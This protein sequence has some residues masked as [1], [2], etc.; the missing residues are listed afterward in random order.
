[1]ESSKAMVGKLLQ[2][3]SMHLTLFIFISAYFW[4]LLQAADPDPVMDIPTSS[5]TFVLRDLFTN[6]DVSI[7]TGGIRAA[8]N[9]TNLPLT[10][11]EGITYVRFK[12][13]PCGVNL[14]HTH[15][16]AAE[17]LTLLSGGPLQ[18][19][20][21]DTSG[22]RHI[23]IIHPGDVTV[24][25]RGLLHYEIN[26]GNQTARYISALNSQNPGT[27]TASLAL[28]RVPSRALATSLNQSIE[29]TRAIDST[30]FMYGSGLKLT[31]RSGC[32]PAQDITTAF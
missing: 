13:Y 30:L 22:K 12:M 25:P 20:F 11:S 9:T 6:G 26:V 32:V 5:N 19:G 16:R 31:S 29:E 1:M 27:L 3:L 2:C 18:V 15:P 24:F 17:I 4:Q 28:F 10:Q 21:I 8:V 14:P 7:D 23:N